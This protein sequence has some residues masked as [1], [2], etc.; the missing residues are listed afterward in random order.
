MRASA[1]SGANDNLL[2]IDPGKL[3][4]QP[5]PERP[6]G[7]VLAAQGQRGPRHRVVPLFPRIVQFLTFHAPLLL[8]REESPSS[9]DASA[10]ASLARARLRDARA[11]DDLRRLS[12]RWPTSNPR[13]RFCGRR[14]RFSAA[15]SANP[16][17]PAMRRMPPRRACGAAPASPTRDLFRHTQLRGSRSRGEPVPVEQRRPGDAVLQL[18]SLSQRGAGRTIPSAAGRADVRPLRHASARH[19][20]HAA[21]RPSGVYHRLDQSAR[22]DA[23]GWRRSGWRTTPSI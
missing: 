23:R 8:D 9:S 10:G 7:I 15:W 18:A 5:A 2:E 1:S 20:P 13:A 17:A 3:G 19:D 16:F 22:R 6:G 12:K 11:V 21:A 14:R 4:H